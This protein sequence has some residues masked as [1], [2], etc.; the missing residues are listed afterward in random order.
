MRLHHAGAIF[1]SIPKRVLDDVD[2]IA[3]HVGRPDD[4]RSFDAGV[5]VNS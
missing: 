1:V 5:I 2:S 4:Y 3:D